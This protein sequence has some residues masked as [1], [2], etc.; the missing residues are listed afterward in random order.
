MALEAIIVV[1]GALL[2]Y[3]WLIYPLVLR[4]IAPRNPV[5]GKAGPTPLPPVAILIAAHNEAQGIVA[6]LRNIADLDYPAASVRVYVGDDGS[7]DGTAD[8]VSTWARTHANVTLIRAEQ[9]RGK[10]AMLKELVRKT[11]EE[12]PSAECRVPGKSEESERCKVQGVRQE[13]RGS[14]Q[15]QGARGEVRGKG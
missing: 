13:V 11:A 5:P 6:R 8:A 2:A 7:D 15:A 14:G 1:G 9:R 3:A 4:W 12:V 10:T